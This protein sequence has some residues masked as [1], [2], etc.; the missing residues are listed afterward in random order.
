MIDPAWDEGLVALG[1]FAWD[2][3]H[4]LLRSAL[5]R[6]AEPRPE[7]LEGLALASWWLSDIETSIAARERAFVAFSAAGDGEGAA[8]MALGLAEDYAASSKNSV[9][10]AWMGRAE[11]ILAE[12]PDDIATG[13]LE[14]ARARNALETERDPER[15]LRHAEEARRIGI[16]RGD[17]NLEMLARHDRGQ[18]LVASGRVTEG[19]REME[20]VM[21]AAGAG[22]LDALTTGRVY[23]NMIATCLDTADFGT[24]AEWSEEAERWCDAVSNTGGYPGMC[25]VRRSEVNR[26]RGLL[27]AAALGAERAV[28]ELRSFVPL[29]AAAHAEIGNVHLQRGDLEAAEREFLTAHSMGSEPMPGLA[30]LRLAQGRGDQAASLLRAALEARA[31]VVLERVRLLPAAAEVFLSVGDVDGSEAAAAD[32]TAIAQDYGS[33]ALAASAAFARARVLAVRED[34]RTAA[35][36][37]REAVAAWTEVGLPLDAAR[38]RAGLGKSLQALGELAAGDLEVTAAAKEFARLGARLELSA[39]GGESSAG[40][41][42]PDQADRARELLSQL[43]AVALGRYLIVGGYARFAPEDRHRLADARQRIVAGLMTTTGNREN[44]LV[45]APPGSGK[46]YFVEQVAAAL[47]EVRYVELNLARL[48]EGDFRAS[49][50]QALAGSGATLVFVD[51]IDAKPDAAWPY[52]LLLP[53][54][55][56]NTRGDGRVVFVM[57]GSGGSS[58]EEFMAGIAARAKGTDL[59][60]RIPEE[61]HVVVGSLGV[62]DQMLVAL[63]QVTRSAGRSGRV[64]RSIEKGALFYISVTPYLGNARQLTEFVSR[65]VGRMPAGED[66]IKYD[67]LFAPGDPEN[68]AFWQRLQEKAPALI[69]SYVDVTS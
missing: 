12:R 38:A 39:L 9:A 47:P 6:D 28:I 27:D 62:G 19:I 11:Q 13:Y 2:D 63:T 58:L 1:R 55:D 51:E 36:Q 29:A 25:R 64:V 22:E 61:N 48:D 59:L 31:N 46:S 37:F 7:H 67:H 17:R 23:C 66:R 15:A 41:H 8:R 4:A 49:L 18:I 56:I 54:L 44:H 52:E 65:A 20:Q 69:G 60:S 53:C 45:W 42:L 5:A 14:R 33:K 57:A 10:R 16:E 3:S 24:A 35:V 34:H 32:L 30:M 50:D 26:R 21:I 40:P 43:D 68:K